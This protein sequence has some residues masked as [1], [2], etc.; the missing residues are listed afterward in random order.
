MTNRKKILFSQELEN[1]NSESD[2]SMFGMF[3]LSLNVPNPVQR[4]TCETAS[5]W[6][7]ISHS[8]NSEMRNSLSKYIG[9]IVICP[10]PPIG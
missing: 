2:N 5:F 7:I 1:E 6:I 10:Y 4:L 3:Q 9:Q 8:I